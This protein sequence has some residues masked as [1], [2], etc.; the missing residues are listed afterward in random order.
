[1]KWFIETLA[2]AWAVTFWANAGNIADEET[3]RNIYSFLN[4]VNE[5]LDK[6][7]QEEKINPSILQTA[8]NISYSS[9]LIIKGSKRDR[10]TAYK[11]IKLQRKDPNENLLFSLPNETIELYTSLIFY[12]KWICLGNQ[13]IMTVL[14]EIDKG[15]KIEQE[16]L[17]NETIWW[18]L[19]FRTMAWIA[20]W[21]IAI[22][23][24]LWRRKKNNLIGKTID[25]K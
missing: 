8:K 24:W 18:S 15:I 10:D 12:Y 1:M 22:V 7:T 17:Q 11:I 16:K 19:D 13:E 25:K 20:S 5:C 4:K 14:K 21:P 3:P 23:W 2:L 9:Q 6:R